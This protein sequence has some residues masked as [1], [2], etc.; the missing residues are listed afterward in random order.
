MEPGELAQRVKPWCLK[1]G[2]VTEA[3]WEAIEPE[4]LYL[5]IGLLRERSKTLVELADVMEILFTEDLPHEAPIDLDAGGRAAIGAI[6]EALEAAEPFTVERVEETIRATLAAQETKL[7][8]VAPALR[9]AITG[10]KVGP[11]LFEIVAAAGKTLAA[12]RLR[13]IAGG[14]ESKG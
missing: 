6:A 5:G 3:Q 11:G 9:M 8:A 4:R 1:E 10:R 14:K 12:R 13:A 7:K 2:T